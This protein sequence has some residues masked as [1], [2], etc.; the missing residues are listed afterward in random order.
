MSSSQRKVIWEPKTGAVYL[1]GVDGKDRVILTRKGFMEAFFDEIE[2]VGGKDTL[3]MVFR[4]M[5][6]KLG[7]PAQFLDHPTLEDVTRFHDGLILPYLF[8]EGN[9][10]ESFTPISG[11]RE[12][13]AYGDTVFTF[14]TVRLLQRFKEAMGEIL[15]DRGAA[16]ILH[17]V[18]KRGGFAVAQKALTDYDW[19]EMD[20]ALESMDAVLASVFPLYGWGLSR[21]VVGRGKDN[22]RMFFLKCWNIYEMDT[23][24]S[25][26]PLCIVH[27]SYLEGIGECLS[28]R[29][30]DKAVESREVKCRAR[31]DGYCGFFIV[32]K[33]KDEKG[34]EWVELEDDWKRLDAALPAPDK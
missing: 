16:A 9:M 24:T 3:T 6:T 31:G 17:R 21:T 19:K 18:A 30:E 20:G 28:R 5:L 12:L 4:A 22:R 11:N 15:T 26:K 33:Q 1:D 14:Q 13:T 23:I 29:Y 8:E 25:E 10:P 27:Q 32:Q 2:L 7:A 34:I